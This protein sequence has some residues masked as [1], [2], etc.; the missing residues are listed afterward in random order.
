MKGVTEEPR[1]SASPKKAVPTT[2]K[3]DKLTVD[4]IVDIANIILEKLL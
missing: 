1:F 3:V 2:K 4:D